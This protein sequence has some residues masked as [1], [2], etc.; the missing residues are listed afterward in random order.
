LVFGEQAII[1]RK[2]N[3]KGKPSGKPALVGFNFEF[4]A[5]LV[6]NGP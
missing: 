1:R 4:S 3:K 2:T 5:P 6:S